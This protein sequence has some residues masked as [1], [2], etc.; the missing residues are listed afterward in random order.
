MSGVTRFRISGPV[1]ERQTRSFLEQKF[2][3]SSLS[4]GGN[5]R[6]RVKGSG[7]ADMMSDAMCG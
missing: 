1:N 5:L 3:I 2:R 7:D 4:S 6:K